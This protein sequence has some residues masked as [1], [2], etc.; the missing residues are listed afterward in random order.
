MDSLLIKYRS[1]IQNLPANYFDEK[2]LMDRDGKLSIYYAPF[3]YIN[4]D[5]KVVIVGITPGRTQMMNAL[6]EAKHQL[7]TGADNHTVLRQAKLTGAFSGTLRNNLVN[8][9]DHIGINQWLNIDTT[10]HLFGRMAHLAQ[11]T[12]V[13]SYPVFV[14]GKDYNGTP[15]MLRHPLLKKYLRDYFGKQAQEFHRS[16]FIPLGDKPKEALDFL[17]AEGI[18]DKDKILGDLPH[19]SGANAER[20]AYFLGRKSK[21]SLFDKT[22]PQKIDMARK[23]IMKKISIIIE[24]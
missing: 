5:A 4:P 24:K 12:S 3:E 14:D 20:I 16:L 8:L 17:S 10:E 2:L 18:I 19:P 21:E 22:N 6:R 9:L 23:E 11:T 15:N 13:L 1:V 7:K